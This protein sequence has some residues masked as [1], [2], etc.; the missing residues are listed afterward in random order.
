[1]VVGRDV[2]RGNYLH[3]ADLGV[4]VAV[5]VAG[6]DKQ[7]Y[8]IFRG[9]RKTRRRTAQ[10]GLAVGEGV[11]DENRERDRGWQ[12]WVPDAKMAAYQFVGYI[13]EGSE[14]A[15]NKCRSRRSWRG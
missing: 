10:D 7:R 3:L 13:L 2:G 14:M 12:A 5:R 6:T 8:T 4:F 15:E 11:I 9:I 1:M